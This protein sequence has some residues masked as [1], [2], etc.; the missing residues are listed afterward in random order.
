MHIQWFG[1]SA[2]LLRGS[3]TTVFVDPFD[4]MDALAQRGMRWDYPAIQ[5]ISAD[6]LLVT[7]EHLD[8]NGVGAINGTPHTIRST[9]GTFESPIGTV[10]A[11]ASEHDQMAGTKRG[12]NSIMVFSLDGLRICHFGDFGQSALRQEQCQIIGAI[13]LLFL[14]VG[15]MSTIDGNLAAQIVRD[16]QPRWVVPMHYRT[17][18]IGFLEPA[19]AFLAAMQS[20]EIM[21]CDGP[22]FET[23]TLATGSTPTVVMPAVPVKG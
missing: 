9:A 7:H 4:N 3:D 17:P 16:L 21:Q 8:H 18:A 6:V 5:G 1:Q 13:D 15:G 23:G 12:P 19:D 10:F 22:S 14:P 20:A 11:I 2:F